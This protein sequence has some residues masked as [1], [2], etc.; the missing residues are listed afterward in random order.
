MTEMNFKVEDMSCGHCVAAI[1]GA[2]E[3]VPGVTDVDTSL[4]K[5]TVTVK[6]QE[7][8]SPD[9]AM[10]AIRGAGYTPELLG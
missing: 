2:L 8:L 5:K 4:E 10:T 3:K 1:K 6:S 9:A 7:D